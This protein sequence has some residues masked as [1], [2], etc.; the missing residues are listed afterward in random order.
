MD[1]G[2]GGAQPTRRGAEPDVAQYCP[3]CGARGEWRKCKLICPT[4]HCSVQVILA[5]VD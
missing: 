5:C 4:E 1:G 3:N 2:E